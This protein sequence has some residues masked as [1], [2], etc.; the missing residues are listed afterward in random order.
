MILWQPIP[1]YEKRPKPL[2]KQ[3]P[4]SPAESL[5]YTQ[6]PVGWKLEL[7]ASEPD[8]L[9][10]DE[11]TGNLDTVTGAHIVDLLFELNKEEGT[12]LVLV[13]HEERLASLC[14]H[15]ITLEAGSIVSEARA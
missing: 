4:L 3:K 6:V 2:P 1:N 13:T 14:Q 12:T 10:A 5:N 11:P 8:I 7:F 15:R 9:F